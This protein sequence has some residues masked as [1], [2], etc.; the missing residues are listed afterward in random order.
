MPAVTEPPKAAPVAVAPV[1]PAPVKKPITAECVAEQWG[2]QCFH[3]HVV[4]LPP[5]W[6]L[7]DLG[8]TKIWATI[9]GGSAA[10]RVLDRLTIC[11]F[12]MTF[13]V[14]A[15]VVAATD[16]GASLAI[17]GKKDMPA[18]DQGLPEIEGWRLAYHGRGYVVV[19]KRSGATSGMIYTSRMEATRALFNM[20]PKIVQ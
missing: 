6:T 12:E 3:E 1:A 15:R 16:G 5:G 20:A 2:G 8:D 19:N 10:F 17:M 4:I 13:L 11:D 14:E 18:R 9:Q 7:N